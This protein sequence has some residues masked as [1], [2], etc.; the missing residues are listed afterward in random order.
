LRLCNNKN[1]TTSED[2]YR[3]KL[4]CCA[5]VHPLLKERNHGRFHGG[6]VRQKVKKAKTAKFFSHSHDAVIRVFDEASNVIETHEHAGDFRE[7]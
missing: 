5:F 3:P 7:P 4:F 1:I 6:E 2:G